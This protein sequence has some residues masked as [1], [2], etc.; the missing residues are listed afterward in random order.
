M[1]SFELLPG[2]YARHLCLLYTH[3]FIN[4]DDG[5]LGFST[6]PTNWLPFTEAGLIRI[7]KDGGWKLYPQIDFLSNSSKGVS[8][9]SIGKISYWI[10]PKMDWQPKIK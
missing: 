7:R 5:Y 6:L 10:R 1:N 2:L 9:G 4:I 3:S 8:T